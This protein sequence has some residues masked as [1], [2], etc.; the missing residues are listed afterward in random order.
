MRI[1]YEG[2]ERGLY[3]LVDELERGGLQV[4][5]EPPMSTR[6]AGEALVRIELYIGDHVAQGGLDAGGALMVKEAIKRY[7]KHFPQSKVD[8]EDE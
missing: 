8:I 7:R 3:A 4:V 6:G 2:P 5:Y 1:K